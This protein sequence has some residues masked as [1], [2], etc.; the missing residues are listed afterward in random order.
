MEVLQDD[1]STQIEF[2]KVLIKV[3]PSSIIIYYTTPPFFFNV[4]RSLNLNI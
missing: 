3:P 4:S 2:K 1:Q